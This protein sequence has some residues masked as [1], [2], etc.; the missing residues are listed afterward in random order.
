MTV[1]HGQ[2]IYGADEQSPPPLLNRSI[3]LH[4][5]AFCDTL[6]WKRSEPISSSKITNTIESQIIGYIHFYQRKNITVAILWALPW[7]ANLPFLRDER[8]LIEQAKITRFIPS[9]D[10]NMNAEHEPRT[11]IEPILTKRYVR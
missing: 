5:V 7:R 9:D 6:T 8:Y 2:Q 10:S 4:S 1:E 3:A 11:E